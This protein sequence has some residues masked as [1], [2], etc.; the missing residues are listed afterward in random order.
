MNW[1]RFAVANGFVGLTDYTDSV[2]RFTLYDSSG[3]IKF[4]IISDPGT[5]NYVQM[6]K[7][8]H[9]ILLTQCMPEGAC[10]FRSY[11]YD[12]KVI[13]ELM[14]SESL[15]RMSRGGSYYH[16][17][18]DRDFSNDARIFDSS[19]KLLKK[20][21]HSSNWQLSSVNDSQLVFQDGDTLRLLSIP[22]L[23]VL[24][25]LKV[26]NYIPN[27]NSCINNISEDGAFYVFGGQRI[28]VVD[29]KNWTYDLIPS[30][31]SADRYQS[32]SS[33][34]IGYYDSN[35]VV[36][37]MSG[38]KLNLFAKTQSGWE[39]V[40]RKYIL[41]NESSAG[42]FFKPV[43][44]SDLICLNFFRIIGN[45]LKLTSVIVEPG[46][47]DNIDISCVVING[48]VYEIDS[49]DPRIFHVL[50]QDPNDPSRISLSKL[51]I[52]RP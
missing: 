24:K 14:E 41:P 33:L 49:A 31:D 34:G 28:A 42:D 17:L 4:S 12:G 45:N 7:D 2:S 11:N 9:L 46:A 52:E 47:L 16:S 36:T 50:E 15:I 10:S 23:R 1:P 20:L 40:I 8:N 5:Y 32:L 18:N 51:L 43:I 37:E 6:E 35:L 44:I 48:Y 29:L 25:E 39:C 26:E 30:I 19:G 13:S 3:I 21:R 27:N 22:D 38:N